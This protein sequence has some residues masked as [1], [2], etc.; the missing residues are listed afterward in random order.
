MPLLREVQKLATGGIEPDFTILLDLPVETGLARRLRAKG[1]QN[2]LDAETQTFHARVRSGY[3]S[4][5]ANEPHR[6]FVVDGTQSVESIATEIWREFSRRFGAWF[7][8]GA[9]PTQKT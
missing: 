6:W 4:L 3:D 7:T 9:A 5:V 2:R 8:P 1:T